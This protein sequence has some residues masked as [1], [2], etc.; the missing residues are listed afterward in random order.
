MSC[1]IVV[2]HATWADLAACGTIRST[3]VSLRA[4]RHKARTGSLNTT[5]TGH[6]HLPYFRL[7]YVCKL[8]HLRI[9]RIYKDTA[10][11]L[12]ISTRKHSARSLHHLRTA[13]L[14][15]SVDRIGVVSYRAYP[16]VTRSTASNL[17]LLLLRLSFAGV[18]T[19]SV[20]A[21]GLELAQR[22][23]TCDCTTP[24]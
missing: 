16:R 23:N 3:L 18:A 9:S 12:G 1:P 20:S 22:L 2:P 13:S 17:S 7:P 6:P 8:S 14:L 4:P 5:L 19:L 21:A 24:H 11:G 15:L 10:L